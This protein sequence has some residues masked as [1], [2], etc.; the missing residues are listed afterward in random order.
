MAIR[1]EKNAI[2]ISSALKEMTHAIGK[3]GGS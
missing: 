1:D 2:L 3:K